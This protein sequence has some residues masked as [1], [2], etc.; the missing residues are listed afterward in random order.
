MSDVRY[1]KV[2]EVQ[3]EI[4]KILDAQVAMRKDMV[5]NMV[6]TLYPSMVAGEMQELMR[7]KDAI[8]KRGSSL[9]VR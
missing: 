6:G 5:N 4:K 8:S 3:E 7:W 9:T 2:E 1:L